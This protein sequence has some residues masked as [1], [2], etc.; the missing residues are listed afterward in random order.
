MGVTGLGTGGHGCWLLTHQACLCGSEYRHH[1]SQPRFEPRAII[2]R[3][4]NL[5]RGCSVSSSIKW[6]AQAL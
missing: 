1:P 5:W 3:V 6:G 4:G 2:C